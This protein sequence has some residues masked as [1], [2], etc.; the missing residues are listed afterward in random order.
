MAK[1]AEGTSVPVERSKQQI[2]AMLK[3]YGATQT[4]FAEDSQAGQVVIQ[5]VANQRSVRFRLTLPDK[6]SEQYT[7]QRYYRGRTVLVASYDA[8]CRQKWR[9]L[10][11]CIKGKFEAVEN[12][13]S[14][15]EDEF[16]ANIVIGGRTTV[17]DIVRP[18]IAESYERG[19]S[20]IEFSGISGF[21]G[22]QG[23]N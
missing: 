4:M 15:F 14:I 11:L 9:A 10:W 21:L 6:N 13:I 2:E 5:F 16:L 18:K 1:Y 7:E 3:K 23:S 22:H 20:D 12:G 19:G 17:S 8:D